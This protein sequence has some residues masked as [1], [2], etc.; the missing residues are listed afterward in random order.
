MNILTDTLDSLFKWLSQKSREADCWP[1]IIKA[2]DKDT[3]CIKCLKQFKTLVRKN[4]K[5]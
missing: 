2:T 4:I 1:H 5:P 3:Y